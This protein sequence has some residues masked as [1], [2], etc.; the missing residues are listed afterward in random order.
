MNNQE[1]FTPEEEKENNERKQ[2]LIELIASGEAILIVG[3]GSSRRVDYPDWPGLLQELENVANRWGDGFKPDTVKCEDDP[4]AYAEDIKSYI[5]EQKN[6]L[7][8]YYASLEQLFEFKD[9]RCKDFHRRLVLLPFRGILTTNYDIVLEVALNEVG[10]PST[11]DNSLVINKDSAGQVDKFLRGLSDAGAPCRI[12]HLHGRYDYPQNIILSSNDYQKAYGLA[13]YKD[14]SEL[15]FL[16]ANQVQ[17]GTEWTLHRKLLWA[18]L[19]TRRV[20]FVGFSME[21]PYFEKMLETVSEDL[22]RW[23]KSIHFAIMS[24][25][26]NSVKD[27]KDSVKDSKDKAER[28]KNR[29][30]VDTLFYED[31]DKSHLRLDHIVAEI[32]KKCGVEIQPTIITQEQADDNNRAVDEEPKPAL[33]KS[34]DILIRLEEI[35]QRVDKLMG[36]KIDNEN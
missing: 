16:G 33:S 36:R 32:A 5:C 8:R 9:S 15:K 3:A 22:W 31:S 20:V 11:P 25:S 35:N 27:L 12:A 17:R 13:A 18:V 1:I 24:I 26:P 19:A 10:Q 30:G 2:E 23:D 6:G 29:Y 34:A 28:L 14:I 4:L 21:D 7:K